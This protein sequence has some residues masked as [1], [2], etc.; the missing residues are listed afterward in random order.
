MAVE[1]K[2]VGCGVVLLQAAPNSES[3]MRG[4]I[5]RRK[6]IGED[7]LSNKIDTHQDMDMQP[8][9]CYNIL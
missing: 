5:K 6:V 2:L 1:G 7:S 8:E 4:R 3:K 9:F